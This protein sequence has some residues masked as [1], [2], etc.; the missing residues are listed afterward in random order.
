MA[1]LTIQA[2]K[3]SVASAATAPACAGLGFLFRNIDD[4]ISAIDRLAVHFQRGFGIF[5]RGKR[6]ESKAA[7]LAAIAVCNQPDFV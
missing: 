6:D 2:G 7:R 5:L 1:W 3:F 4:Q